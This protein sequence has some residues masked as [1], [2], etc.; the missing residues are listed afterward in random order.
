MMDETSIKI[1]FIYKRVMLQQIINN[2]YVVVFFCDMINGK[3][4]SSYTS[5]YTLRFLFLSFARLEIKRVW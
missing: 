3:L 1:Q 2:D 5:R 4:E